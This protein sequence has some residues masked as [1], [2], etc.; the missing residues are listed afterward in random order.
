M[1]SGLMVRRNPRDGSRLLLSALQS[2]AYPLVVT[3][4]RRAELREKLAATRAQL[5]RPN[6]RSSDRTAGSG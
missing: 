2:T 3:P 4:D 6:T 1:G 5:G